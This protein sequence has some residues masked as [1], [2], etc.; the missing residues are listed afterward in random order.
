MLSV[1]KGLSLLSQSVPYKPTYRYYFDLQALLYVCYSI[2]DYHFE[3]I[4]IENEFLLSDE[5]LS[6]HLVP[7][8]TPTILLFTNWPFIFGCLGTDILSA[9]PPMARSLSSHM[10]W[11]YR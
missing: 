10:L 5:W 6:E 4:V 8:P 1:Y 11:P 9:L 7:A 3:R 2:S